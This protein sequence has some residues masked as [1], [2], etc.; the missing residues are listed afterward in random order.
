MKSTAQQLCQHPGLNAGFVDIYV[1]MFKAMNFVFRCDEQKLSLVCLF[2][3]FLRHGETLHW[4]SYRVVVYTHLYY[5]LI[6]N[7]INCVCPVNSPHMMH[8]Y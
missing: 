7:R 4:H 5:I 8:I 6:V 1:I 2:V 3:C